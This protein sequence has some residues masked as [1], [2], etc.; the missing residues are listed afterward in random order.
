MCTQATNQQ[1]DC[2][3]LCIYVAEKK[4]KD[5]ARISKWVI[6]CWVS[7][8][9]K[10]SLRTLKEYFSFCALSW[11]AVAITSSGPSF[12]VH[13]KAETLI[14]STIIDTKSLQSNYRDTFFSI[15]LVFRYEHNYYVL[16]WKYSCTMHYEHNN[17]GPTLALECIILLT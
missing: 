9:R 3:L 4:Y 14:P 10:S 15:Y 8:L 17:C 5:D 6:S 12:W 11:T 7:D 16:N 13:R 2:K 1:E